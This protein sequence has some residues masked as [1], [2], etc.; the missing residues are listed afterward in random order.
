MIKRSRCQICNAKGKRIYSTTLKTNN[1]R[2]FFFE[3]YGKKKPVKTFI[4][5]I[6]NY[7]YT[8]LKCD[9]CEFIW[10]KNFLNKNF[11]TELY[12]KLIPPIKSKKK[13]EKTSRIL[14]KTYNYEIDLYKNIIGKENIQILD[15]GSG[16][17]FWILSLNYNLKNIFALENSK[18]RINHLRKKKINIIKLN[19]LNKRN[20]K[21]DF[22]R[23]EQVLEHLD[24]FDH[25]LSSLKKLISKDGLIY[26]SV[27]NSKILFKKAWRENLLIKGPAQPLEHINSFTTRSLHKLLMK[28]KYKTVSPFYLLKAFVDCKKFSFKS[29]K[30]TLRILINNIN[31]T[32]ILFKI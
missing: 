20:K 7:E 30:T 26:L 29:I 8:L 3:Y 28:H 2:N 14:K 4:S 27:P 15:Y 21:F 10:Q 9:S 5:K 18:T 31:G 17:G 11:I 16:W 12:D 24:N 25:V 23:L 1:L 6:E 13:S 32:S 22:I 19:T